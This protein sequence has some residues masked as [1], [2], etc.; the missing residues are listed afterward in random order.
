MKY[1]K[2]RAGEIL[3]LRGDIKNTSAYYILKGKIAITKGVSETKDLERLRIFNARQRNTPGK[4]D[5][6]SNYEHLKIE[7]E[8]Q[9]AEKK[10]KMIRIPAGKSLYM[11]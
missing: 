1:K 4:P 5:Y 9:I 3:F 7:T 11:R 6:I 10:K 2:V 8:E